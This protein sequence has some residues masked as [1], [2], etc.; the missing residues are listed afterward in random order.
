VRRSQ[1]PPITEGPHDPSQLC[2]A[3]AAAGEPSLATVLAPYAHTAQEQA[4]RSVSLDV[5]DAARDTTAAPKVS[6]WSSRE[7]MITPLLGV[8]ATPAGPDTSLAR[9]EPGVDV[10]FPLPATRIAPS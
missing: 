7:L 2:A 5:T 10:A 8:Q 1:P 4:R 9:G 3:A 6:A